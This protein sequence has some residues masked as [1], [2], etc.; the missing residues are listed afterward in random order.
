M[1][2]PPPPGLAPSRLSRPLL[3]AGVLQLGAVLTPAVRA[4]I[5]GT[6]PF[7]RLPNAG[8]V[9]VALGVLT[10]AIAF[11]PGGWW[12][13]VPGALSAVIVAVAY[14][15]IVRAPSGSF[16]DPVLRHAV[17]PGWGFGAMTIAI[18]FSLG[19]AALTRRIK[20]VTNAFDDDDI[21]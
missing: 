15:K 13:W 8:V 2:I 9:L 17:H 1:T 12:R 10:I 19:S 14:V 20:P 7:F 18:L 11:R 16:F 3:A 21:V 4:R 5:V 6:I